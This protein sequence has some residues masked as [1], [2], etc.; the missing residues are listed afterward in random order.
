MRPK[1]GDGAG[2]GA[3]RGAGEDVDRARVPVVLA[4]PDEDVGDEQHGDGGEEERQRRGAAD[5]AGGALRV[6]VGGHARRHQGDGDADGLPD[7]EAAAKRWCAPADVVA[8]R[9]LLTADWFRR[10][11]S[12]VAHLS[13]VHQ[14]HRARA[15]RG[16]REDARGPGRP[17]RSGMPRAEELA[18]GARRPGAWSASRPASSTTPGISRV[19]SVP[20]GRLPQLAAWGVGFSTAFDYFRFD[21]W[22]AAPPSGAGPVGDQRIV[23]DLGRLVVLAG[24][25]RLGVGAGRPLR[26]RTGSRT[27]QDS[28]LLLRRLVDALAAAGRRRSGR[29]RDRVGG[30]GRRRATTSSPRRSGP[31]YGHG[32][33]DAPPPT[34]AATCWQ[35]W[36]RRGSRSSSS[37][38]STRRASSSCRSPPEAPVARGGHLGAGAARRS[39]R[40]GM[41]YG[42]RT[43]F[44]P[45][46]DAAGVG[47]GGH[48]HLSL[49]RDGE[50]LMAGGDRPV[51]ADPRRRG[52]R[53]R[54]ARPTC[55]RCWRW[56][57]PSV[58]SYLRLVPTALGRRVRVLGAGEPGGR[59][60]DGHRL[61]GERGVGREPRGQVRRPAREPLSAAG[62]RCWRRPAGLAAGTPLPEPVDVDPAS[63]DDDELGRRGVVRLPTSLRESLD[64]FLA[65]EVLAR[66]VRGAARR[67]RSRA[68]RESELEELGRLQPG[69]GGRRLPL[70]ALSVR[71]P[72]PARRSGR[73]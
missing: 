60:A 53:R 41:R 20:L 59:A 11:G 29:V 12:L 69:A 61:D 1:P 9:T 31:A 43:S 51:R 32:P 44:S 36:R 30:L 17:G 73:R 2:A 8:M 4:E 72:R 24:P 50:N 70:G 49:W 54:R 48:V 65:D 27:P 63:L 18:A 64:A 62:R 16:P 35:P 71:R 19:K 15:Y 67:R 47:N 40:S 46:V 66:G 39:G 52:V 14:L 68:V 10:L 57:R 58:A 28:R 22:V 7:G 26:R 33:A 42:F 37:T 3:E 25:A 56:A 5:L 13:C 34:T 21:D 6:D 38:R 45:K 23:P 55:R